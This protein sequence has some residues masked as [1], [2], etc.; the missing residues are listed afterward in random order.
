MP[1]AQTINLRLYTDDREVDVHP[2]RYMQRLGIRWKIAV[3]VPVFSAWLFFD[4][5]GIPETLPSPLC[6][7]N[8]QE[9][10]AG[11]YGPIYSHVQPN[12]DE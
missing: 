2:Q 3:P 9:S 8:I 4:C 7:T 11:D 1:K 10:D 12:G 5:S 6:P